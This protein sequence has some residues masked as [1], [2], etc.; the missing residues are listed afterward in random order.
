[1]KA[2]L[3][4]AVFAAASDVAPA[5]S[6]KSSELPSPNV[7]A[8]K[9][10]IF[11]AFQTHSLVGVADYHRLAQELDFYAALVRDKRFAADVGNVVVEFGDAAQQPIID[12]YLAGEDVPYEQLRKVWAD[13]FGW[14]PT[15][16]GLAY[17]NFYAQVRAVNLKLPPE[18]RIHV[19]LGDSPI[20][21]SR[22]KAIGDNAQVPDRDRY[23][24]G[25]IASQILAKKKKA[26]VIYGTYH[27][28]GDGSLKA[29]VEQ[30]YPELSL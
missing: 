30:Q 25:L 20:D 2:L 11:N 4:L 6:A 18:S 22:I 13:T 14:I 28:Y 16:V 17:M 27:F 24:A 5:Q 21:W 26:L 9:Q 3:L 23:A 12:R 10:G 7:A 8:A 15:V 1:M 29:L 19:W